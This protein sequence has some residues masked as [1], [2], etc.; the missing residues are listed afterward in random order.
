MK[1]VIKHLYGQSYVLASLE[2]MR[3]DI[4]GSKEI[5]L[6]MRFDLGGDRDQMLFKICAKVYDYK[7]MM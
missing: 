3:N 1:S 4:L 6:R 7:H 5:M 2:E